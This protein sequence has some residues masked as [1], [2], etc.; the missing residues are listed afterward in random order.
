[1][2]LK[3]KGTEMPLVPKGICTGCGNIMGKCGCNV[4]SPYRQS[5]V[6]ITPKQLASLPKMTC[7]ACKKES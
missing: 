1:M 7:G 3:V 5:S 6:T 4:I 2:E